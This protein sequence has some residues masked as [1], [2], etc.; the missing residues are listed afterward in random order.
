[1]RL[2]L[3]LALVTCLPALEV[4]TLRVPRAASVPALDAA[5]VPA[6]VW[7][8]A[9]LVPRLVASIDRSKTAAQVLPATEVRLL[10]DEKA[11][12]V[13]FDCTDAEVYLPYD[14]HDDPLYQGDVVEVFLDPVGDAR[15]WFELQVAANNATFD[16]NLVLTGEAKS[17][18]DGLLL[19]AVLDR[20]WWVSKDYEM[21]GLTT[22][23]RKHAAGWSVEMAIP[24]RSAARRLGISAWAAGLKLR[25]NLMRYEWGPPDAD[26]KR[27]F[28]PMNWAPVLVGCP[29]IS[30][31]AMGI[32]EL[33]P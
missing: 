27:A 20:E 6:A 1:M 30:P 28:M 8:N 4:P 9:A 11:L 23:A 19:S 31:Q 22:A 15:Q 2:L 13:R 18:A 10:W 17:N 24:A 21:E 5:A 25:A 29:H 14:K 16:Q 26:G 3:L 33:V 7:N 32:L 12:Y